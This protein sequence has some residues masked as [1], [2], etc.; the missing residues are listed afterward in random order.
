MSTL[1]PLSRRDVLKAGGALIVTFAFEGRLPCLA[2]A[3]GR[4]VVS[5]A[6]KP[7][8]PKLVDSFIAIH[9]DGTVIVY[10]GKVDIGTGMR[11]AVAQMAGEELGIAPSRITVIDGD[12]GLCPDQG[13]TGGS[14]GLTRGGM[15]IRRAAATARQAL[16]ARAAAQVGRP[17]GELT[18]VDG[19]IRP[20]A[21]GTG[22]SIASLVGDRQL[23]INVDEKAPLGEPARFAVIGK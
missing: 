8:D 14:N 18:I 21:G 16:L 7:L 15:E 6:T 12:T 22:V 23:S 4:G 13:G 1:T 11:I 3:Q 19:Q 9:A 2:A 10:S 5:D 17:A 20:I